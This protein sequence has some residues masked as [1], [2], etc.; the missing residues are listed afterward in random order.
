MA[1]TMPCLETHRD[2]NLQHQLKKQLCALFV[3]RTEHA[4]IISGP[5][6]HGNERFDRHEDRLQ[7]LWNQI[8]SGMSLHN[9]KIITVME[10]GISRG[11]SESIANSLF[12]VHVTHLSHVAVVL[13]LRHTCIAKSI[14]GM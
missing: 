9:K 4:P 5:R 7:H 10:S 12:T 11:P 6:R 1:Y 13:N 2:A 3:G 8:T 14:I